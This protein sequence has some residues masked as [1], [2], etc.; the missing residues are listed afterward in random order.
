MTD[1]DRGVLPDR[2][3]GLRIR[4]SRR[5]R[6]LLRSLPEQLRPLVSGEEEA[7]T[8]S[9]V[10]FSRGYDDD[11]QEAE[12][13]SLAGD[14]IV[15][16]RVAALDAFADTLDGGVERDGAWHKELDAEEAGAW[17]SAVNDGRLVLAA[18]LGINDES[19]WEQ[20]PDEDNPASIVLDYLSW[21]QTELVDAMMTSLPEAEGPATGG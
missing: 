11:A 1:L 12:F 2:D 18:L 7:P 10:L 19:Q 9:G 3:G 17:L 20:G 16:Q 15:S 5:E 4:L 8:V 21:L 13:R 6:D 14:D